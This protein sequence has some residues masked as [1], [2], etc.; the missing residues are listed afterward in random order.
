MQANP[1]IIFGAGPLGRQ[2][3]ENFNSNH[4]VVYC[5]LDDN[6]K[7]HN[8][9]IDDIT[10]MG[11]MDDEEYIKMIGKKCDA[12]IATDNYK[13]KSSLTKIIMNSCKAMPSNCIH[14]HTSVAASAHIGYGNMINA[15]SLINAGAKIT[16]HCMLGSGSIIEYEATLDE[17][18]HIGAGATI[19]A[20]AEIAEGAYI[21]A[22]ALVVAG[23]KIGK[24]ARV[25]AG[26]VVISHV[27]A[28]ATVFGNP[29]EKI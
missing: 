8:T 12:F 7:L 14:R 27:E 1:V 25:G 24:N 29:A 6:V 17:Y 18:V 11:S 20:G 4:V 19:G 9:V 21:G 16:N 15:G 5:F 13:L 10:V 3:L 2:A 26:S 28:G 22:G 23:V